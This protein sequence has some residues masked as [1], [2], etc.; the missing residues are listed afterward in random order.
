MGGGWEGGERETEGWTEWEAGGRSNGWVWVGSRDGGWYR[1]PFTPNLVSDSVLKKSSGAFRKRFL[2][3]PL[4]LD[5][6]V[7]ASPVR[8][9]ALRITR[10]FSSAQLS[11]TGHRPAWEN[12]YAL[13]H[14]SQRLFLF[15][16]VVLETFYNDVCKYHSVQKKTEKGLA[17]DL[18]KVMQTALVIP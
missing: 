5:P 14:I 2:C 8:S 3:T 13:P 10:Q 16:S 6:C 17:N 18:R 7:F 4:Q 9:H 12:P 15:S 11:S 1:K